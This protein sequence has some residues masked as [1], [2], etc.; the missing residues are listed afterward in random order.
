MS[1]SYSSLSSYSTRHS[2]GILG[3]YYTRQYESYHLN[4][5]DDD[6]VV[7]GSRKVDGGGRARAHCGPAPPGPGIRPYHHQ[8]PKIRF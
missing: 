4:H 5:Q 1:T 3:G 8:D 6:E 7:D 2:Y